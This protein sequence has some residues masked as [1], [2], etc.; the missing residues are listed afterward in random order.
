MI[1]QQLRNVF[2]VQHSPGLGWLQAQHQM[3]TQRLLDIPRLRFWPSG[4]KLKQVIQFRP[5]SKIMRLVFCC[6]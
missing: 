4:G 6:N 1:Q 2:V 5:T 3:V